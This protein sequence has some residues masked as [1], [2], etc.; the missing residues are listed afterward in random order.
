MEACWLPKSSKNRCH[1]QEAIF[2]KPCFSQGKTIILKDPG[3][4]IG[5]KNRSKI[6]QKRRSTWEGILTSIFHRFWW[7]LGAKLGG[8]IEPRSMQNGIEK[9]IEKRKASGNELCYLTTHSPGG[10]AALLGRPEELFFRK[11]KYRKPTCKK[12][13]L[14]KRP[15]EPL[16]LRIV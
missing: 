14:K 1:L 5:S 11:T 16:A 8:K 13:K 10:Y 12:K 7:I 2:R 15:G 3:V 6:Y 9:T 4:E